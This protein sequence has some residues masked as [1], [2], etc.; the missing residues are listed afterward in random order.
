MSQR[1]MWK[2]AG[3]PLVTDPDQ[4]P[5]SGWWLETYADGFDLGAAE[6]VVSVRESLLLDGDDESIDHW[7]NREMQWTT[8]VCGYSWDDLAEG[9]KALRMR[10][11]GPADLV[12][13]PPE[14]GASTLFDVRTSQWRPIVNDLDWIKKGT[15]YHAYALSVRT[16]PWGYGLE[17]VTET[18]TTG[19]GTVT[20]VDDGTSATNWPGMSVDS[21]LGTTTVALGLIAA[22]GSGQ[23]VNSGYAYGFGGPTTGTTSWECRGTIQYSAAIPAVAYVWVDLAVEGAGSG[24][25]MPGFMT[26]VQLSMAGTDT[27]SPVAMQAAPVAGYTRYFWRRPNTTGFRI[28]ASAAAFEGQSGTFHVDGYGTSTTL[29]SGSLL[30]LSM[31]GSVP[32]QGQLQIAHPTPTSASLGDVFVYADPTMLDNGWIPDDGTTFPYAPEG[33]YWLWVQAN[34]ASYSSGEVFGVTVG[35]ITK[36]TRTEWAGSATPSNGRWFPIGPFDLGVNRSRVLGTVSG[37][38]DEV[39]LT[40]N[41]TPL[42]SLS[43]A[44]LIREDEDATLIHVRDLTVASGVEK[45]HLFID[46]PS[47]DQPRPGF[48]AGEA[49]DGSDAVSV[50]ATVDSQSYPVLVPGATALWVQVKNTTTPTVTAVHRPAYDPFATGV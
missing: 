34:A 14:S 20:T 2:L 49:A 39:T 36:T 12:L 4:R 10:L 8:A 25:V 16:A 19:A 44:R 22:T 47:F 18:F 35:G 9:A 23:K 30:G 33:T 41:G 26:G 28:T 3:L 15:K 32:V 40:R 43:P 50:A 46:P 6:G 48:Y 31:K 29:P 27:G 5:T 21:Y 37:L 11:G 1:F 42:G 13:T 45:S 38:N 7:G 24:L 17:K